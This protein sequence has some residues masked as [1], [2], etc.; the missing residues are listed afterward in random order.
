MND[1]AFTKVLNRILFR[2]EIMTKLEGLSKLIGIYKSLLK[3]LGD[4]TKEVKYSRVGVCAELTV[5]VERLPEEGIYIK[6]Y[7]ELQHYIR[8]VINPSWEFFSGDYA[9]PVP[10]PCHRYDA[11]SA[12]LTI[13]DLW[14]S[15]YGDMRRLYC[16]YLAEELEKVTEEE[17]LAFYLK[18]PYDA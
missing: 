3:G 2:G 5:M 18:T 17:I 6:G 7:E 1:L 4:G 9:Y 12:F 10:H 16:T 14:A 11:M 13:E 8:E 15:D